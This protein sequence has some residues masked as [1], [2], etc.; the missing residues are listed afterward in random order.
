[1]AAGTNEDRVGLCGNCRHARIVE[2]PR[3]STFYLCRRS[4]SDA[5]FPKYPP[6]PVW[7]CIGYEPNSE[8]QAS[9][10]TGEEP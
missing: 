7:T 5:R 1:M 3:G 6:L 10:K 9:S 4:E 8:P 2:S